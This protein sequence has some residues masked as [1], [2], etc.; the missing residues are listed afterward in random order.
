MSDAPTRTE[1][2]DR[3]MHR[4]GPFGIAFAIVSAWI[5][6]AIW[7]GDAAVLGE[8]YARLRWTWWTLL[9]AWCVWL[10]VSWLVAWKFPPQQPMQTRPGEASSPRRGPP[11]PGR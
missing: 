6:I 5:G 2:L 9:G 7:K 3:A 8:M 1:A 11:S 10:I 4:S